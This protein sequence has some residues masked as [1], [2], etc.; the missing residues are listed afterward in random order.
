MPKRVNW[1]IMLVE[2]GNERRWPP[3]LGPNS[4]NLVLKLIKPLRLGHFVEL[5]SQETCV[6]WL[7]QESH[8]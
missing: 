7:A 8:Q 2:P 6:A 3:T 5:M 4:C 1:S